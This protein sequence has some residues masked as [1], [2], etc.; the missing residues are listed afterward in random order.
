M[1]DLAVDMLDIKKFKDLLEKKIK[2]EL[3]RIK[4]IGS[5]N[6]LNLS[7]L[8]TQMKNLLLQIFKKVP[9]K[10]LKSPMLP[11]YRVQELISI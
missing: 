6:T 11:C 3:K 2:R 4:L 10:C 5:Q 8:V 9:M 1:K 7:H